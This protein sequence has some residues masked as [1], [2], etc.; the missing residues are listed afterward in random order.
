VTPV[1]LLGRLSELGV[2]VHGT[3]GRRVRLRGPKTFLSDD[4]LLYWC[5]RYRWLWDSAMSGSVSG[6]L[7]HGCPKCGEVQLARPSDGIRKCVM[8]PECEGLL[9][10]AVAPRIVERDVGPVPTCDRCGK[11]HRRLIP[12]FWSEWNEAI[13]PG[14]VKEVEDGFNGSEW[15]EISSTAGGTDP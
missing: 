7:W 3:P 14:C 5:R 13:C 9:S 15:P 11:A 1:E 12:T 10:P 8:T 2:E 6:H 4:E